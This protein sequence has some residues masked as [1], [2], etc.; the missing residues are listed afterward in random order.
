M[1]FS[2]WSSFLLLAEGELDSR[3][4]LAVAKDAPVG[5]RALR[6]RFELN[7]DA[8]EPTVAKLVELTERYCVVLQT[9]RTRPPIIVSHDEVESH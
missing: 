6:L 1:P 7:V 9:L 2:S 5:F 8:D 3:G 4:T